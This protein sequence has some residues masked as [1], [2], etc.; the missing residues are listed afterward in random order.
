MLC[1]SLV[2]MGK[3]SGCSSSLKRVP[4]PGSSPGKDNRE[5]SLLILLWGVAGGENRALGQQEQTENAVLSS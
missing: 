3:K 5:L 1:S 4:G 2:Q